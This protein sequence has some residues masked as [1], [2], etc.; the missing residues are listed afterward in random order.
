MLVDK[1]AKLEESHQTLSST[2]AS[3]QMSY[4]S[5]EQRMQSLDALSTEQKVKSHVWTITQLV[6][7]KLLH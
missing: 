5:V 6:R 3:L 7:I 4:N 1:H 2:L